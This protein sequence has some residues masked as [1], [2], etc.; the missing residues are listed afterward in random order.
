MDRRRTLV[1]GALTATAVLGL[2]G[3][4]LLPSTAPAARADGL[5]AY[6]SCAEMLTHYRAELATTVTAWGVGGGGWPVAAAARDSAAHGRLRGRRRGRVGS[7]PTG[8]NLQEQGVDE[9]DLAKLADGRL[10]VLT[11]DRL[12]VVSAA[13]QPVVLGSVQVGDERSYGGELLLDGDRALVVVPS[14][15]DEGVEPTFTVDGTGD[16]ATRLFP[17]GTPTTRLV[18]VD[19]TDDQPR[20]LE[21]AVLDGQYVSARLVG[22]TVRLVTT[23]RPT[24]PM[25][26]P[27]RPGE[28]AESRALAV[29][30]ANVADLALDD[31]LPRVERRDADGRVLERGP[32]VSCQ[33]TSY[34]R[35]AAGAATLLITTLRPG[36]DLAATDR[37][38]VTTDGDLVYAASDRLYVATSR[39]GTTGVGGPAVDLAVPG[40]RRGTTDGD[41]QLGHRRGEHRAAR[42]RHDRVHQ[43]RLRRQ[44]DGARLR[45]GPLGALP[46]R[47]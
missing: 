14:Y 22:G 13:A 44:R 29:N 17:P 26:Y 42:V 35:S 25:T 15:R 4:Q 21:Q 27:M 11:G 33:E 2:G 9:P 18:L 31:V 34:A 45:H 8:T 43:H 7:G 12:R 32:A 38:A 41:R 16:V 28:A 47:G 1:A 6:G 19:L 37:T 3:V 20:V 30:R 23:S 36:D 10:V 40:V 46:P 24:L 39:W 5:V